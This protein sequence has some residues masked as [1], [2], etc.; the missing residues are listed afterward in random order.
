MLEIVPAMSTSQSACVSLASM[1]C[2]RTFPSSI[3]TVSVGFSATRISG[4]GRYT[5]CSSPGVGSLSNVNRAPVAR[6]TAVVSKV[7]D[8]IRKHGLQDPADKGS[9]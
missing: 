6:P 8:H 9:C 4:W 7:W 5:R 2:R 3:N 1:T